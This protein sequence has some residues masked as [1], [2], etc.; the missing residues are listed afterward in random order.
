MWTDLN[1]PAIKSD[2]TTYAYPIIDVVN[3]N[4]DLPT[5]STAN[6]PFATG[7]F[8]VDSTLANNP[9]GA[10][11]SATGQYPLPM[12]VRWLYVLKQGQI[13]APDSSSTDTVVTFNNAS[14]K[15]ISNPSNP[16]LDNPIIG[17]IAFGPM[18]TPAASTSTRRP[19]AHS[20]IF[21]ASRRRT[22]D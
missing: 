13:I 10:T 1:A 16:L 7:S 15:P 4:G 20:G 5:G 6:A 9:V 19:T 22:S 12:P 11:R 3:D 18:T 2:G 21:P 17:R 8:N 14:P